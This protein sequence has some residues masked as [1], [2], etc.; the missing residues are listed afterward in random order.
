MA[1]YVT[2]KKELYTYLMARTPFIIVQTVERER[3]ERMLTEIS[4]EY[5]INLD[6]YSD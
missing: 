5:N 6:F 2:L 3:V 1:N 4:E